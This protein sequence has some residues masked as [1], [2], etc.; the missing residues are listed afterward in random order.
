MAHSIG[1]DV[2]FDPASSL[3]TVVDQF[4]E[5]PSILGKVKQYMNSL[6][7]LMTVSVFTVE[8]K[9]RY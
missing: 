3:D 6:T 9:T 7:T 4:K 5:R 8:L 1:N 2:L